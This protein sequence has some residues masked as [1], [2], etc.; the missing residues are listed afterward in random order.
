M[1]KL[2]FLSEN[3]ALIDMKNKFDKKIYKDILD[4]EFIKITI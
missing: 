4:L 2:Y 3:V 1:E